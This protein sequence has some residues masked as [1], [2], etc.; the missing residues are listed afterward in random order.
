M[1]VVTKKILCDCCKKE[2]PTQ[3][4]KYPVLFT[5]EQTEGRSVNPYISY[6]ELDL[7]A[8]CIRINVG[9]AGS[10]AMGYNEYKQIHHNSTIWN[11]FAI[12]GGS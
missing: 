7:C 9:I 10:G 1:E 3:K 4:I 12:K 5:T 11:D 2:K 6:Q 8:D